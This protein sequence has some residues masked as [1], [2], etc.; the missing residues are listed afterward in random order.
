M[1]SLHLKMHC[2]KSEWIGVVVLEQKIFF[3]VCYLSIIPP[4]IKISPVVFEIKEVEFSILLCLIKISPVVFEIKEDYF[5]IIP[6]L[7][8]INPVVVEFWQ[9]PNKWWS[10][11]LLK[12]VQHSVQLKKFKQIRM[13]IWYCFR[14]ISK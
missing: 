13:W 3:T 5:F 10:E 2:A 1:N 14:F 6:P 8:K 9:T 11:K 12:F 4:L 7:T